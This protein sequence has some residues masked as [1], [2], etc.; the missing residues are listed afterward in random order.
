MHVTEIYDNILLVKTDTRHE[1]ASLF[2]R[3]QEF[4][5]SPYDNIKNNRFTMDEYMDT[6]AEDTGAF[7]YLMD[8]TC[9][10]FQKKVKIPFWIMNWHMHFTISH[11]NIG[12][13]CE[14]KCFCIVKVMFG[15]KSIKYYSKLD[16]VKMSWMMR[17]RLIWRL[18]QLGGCLR[19]LVFGQFRGALLKE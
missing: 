16:I 2:M 15:I 18:H 3:I 9:L 4:Y 17:C 13:V 14:Y 11:L 10:A 12:T 8:C 7:T 1:C 19:S 6:H 5:E